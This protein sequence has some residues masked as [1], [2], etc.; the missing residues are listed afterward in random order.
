MI[1]VAVAK[2]EFRANVC[3]IK[4]RCNL[5]ADEFE[6]FVSKLGSHQEYAQYEL[7]FEPNNQNV[8]INLPL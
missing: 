1:F 7:D 3:V 4:K 6:E 5:L 8:P 2:H